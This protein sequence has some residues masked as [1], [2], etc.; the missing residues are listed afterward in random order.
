MIMILSGT[1]PKD[2]G[3]EKPAHNNMHMIIAGIRFNL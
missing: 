2:I 3:D 1:K